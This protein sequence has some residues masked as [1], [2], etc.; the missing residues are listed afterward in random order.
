MLQEKAARSERSWTSAEVIDF[1]TDALSAAY[2]MTCGQ[3]ANARPQGVEAA[4]VDHKEAKLKE[5][6]L[7]ASY[8]ATDDLTL[9]TI[10]KRILWPNRHPFRLH[11]FTSSPNAGPVFD[12]S[13]AAH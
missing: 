13:A 8:K 6:A 11:N 1:G 4:K 2:T 7:R 3:I 9:A 5:A 12:L 10:R